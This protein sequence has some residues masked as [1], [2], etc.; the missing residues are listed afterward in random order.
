MEC[1]KVFINSDFKANER[2]VDCWAG[3]VVTV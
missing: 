2:E 1:W 3:F